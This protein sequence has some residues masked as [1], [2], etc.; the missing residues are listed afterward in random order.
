MPA[1]IPMIWGALASVLAS[2][3]GRVVLALGL[4]AVTYK[5]LDVLVGQFE[6]FINAQ[7]TAIPADVSAILDY[8]GVY[9][10]IKMHL[11]VFSAIAAV[12]GTQR[13][14]KAVSK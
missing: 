7:L 9:V 2:L 3:V 5:G 11:S 13:V 8:L 12:M 1:L 4:S 6:G 14:I 10:V